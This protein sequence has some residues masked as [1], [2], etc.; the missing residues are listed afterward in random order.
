MQ[1][2]EGSEMCVGLPDCMR[3]MPHTR[4]WHGIGKYAVIGKGTGNLCRHNE[5]STGRTFLLNSDLFNLEFIRATCSIWAHYTF[6]STCLVESRIEAL[7][8][9]LSSLNMKGSMY[10]WLHM[11]WTIRD[12]DPC[13]VDL[14]FKEDRKSPT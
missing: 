14:H 6:F 3:E 4:H 11:L 5:I 12:M 1:D 13:Q 9:I 7:C 8:Q 10:T 2:E